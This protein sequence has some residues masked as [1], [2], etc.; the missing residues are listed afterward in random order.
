[1]FKVMFEVMFARMLLFPVDMFQPCH[2][3]LHP[4]LSKTSVLDTEDTQWSL[5]SGATVTEGLCAGRE[6]TQAAS[7]SAIQKA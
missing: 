4:Q 6:G 7:A 1:M 2:L 3:F 5:C